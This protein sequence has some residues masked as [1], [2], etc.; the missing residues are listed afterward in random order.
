VLQL[1]ELPHSNQVRLL[2]I[3]ELASLADGEE[4]TA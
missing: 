1:I 3:D 4:Q 2:A